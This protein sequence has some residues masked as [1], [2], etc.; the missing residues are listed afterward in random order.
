MIKVWPFE[1]IGSVKFNFKSLLKNRTKLIGEFM[2]NI[3]L[4]EMTENE[5]EQYFLDKIQRYA[6][7][8]SQNAPKNNQ[9]FEIKAK[10]Q[11]GNLLPDGIGTLGHYLFNIYYEKNNVGY[12]WVKEDVEKKSAFLYEIYIFDEFRNKGYGSRAMKKIEE[13]MKN[14]NLL[15]LKLHVFG[16]NIEARKLYE[17]IGFE[18]A[19]VNMMKKVE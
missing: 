10:I 5:F 4:V 9:E 12:I 18:I 8:L 6:V 11:L 2:N 1:I 16:S 13:W 7:A 17:R 15:F 14:H 19:G 3:S